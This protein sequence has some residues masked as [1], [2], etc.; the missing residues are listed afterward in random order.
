MGAFSPGL[1]GGAQPAAR[2]AFPR[3]KVVFVTAV[4]RFC[5]G[6]PQETAKADG[7]ADFGDSADPIDQQGGSEVRALMAGHRCWLPENPFGA[8]VLG[9]RNEDF[10][11]GVMG[12]HS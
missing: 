4:S 12:T 1:C 11:A 3:G 8:Q 9:A 6:V 10:S 7:F 5:F 2:G